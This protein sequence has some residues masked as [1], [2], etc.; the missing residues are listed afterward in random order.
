MWRR[1]REDG[2][3]GAREVGRK[4]PCPASNDDNTSAQYD[5]ADGN[6]TKMWPAVLGL[7]KAVLIRSGKSQ[8]GLVSTINSWNPS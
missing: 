8:A 1:M 6:D 5:F 3:G 2:R 7:T 4:A